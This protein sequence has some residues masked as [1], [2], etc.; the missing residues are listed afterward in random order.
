[1]PAGVTVQH[2]GVPVDCLPF[3]ESGRVDALLHPPDAPGAQIIPVSFGSGEL[4][5]LSQLFCLRPSLVEL[6]TG[7]PS[8]LRRVPIGQVE[9][10]LQADPGLL[11]LLVRFLAERLREVQTRE[12]GWLHRGVHGRVGATISRLAQA[13]PRQADGRLLLVTT[14]DAL[15][16]RC[17]VSR[18]K[19]S[20]ELKHLERAGVLRLG[21]GSLEVIDPAPLD[22][23]A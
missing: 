13:T 18:P 23:A 4:A 15:A 19:L 21:R 8:V 10:C 3:I 7:E 17:G 14:H 6:V 2:A 16:A 9:G 12:L 20:L 11:V 5:L 22:P 1:M